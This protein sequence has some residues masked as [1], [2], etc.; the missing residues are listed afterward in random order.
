MAVSCDVCVCSLVLFTFHLFSNHFH[1][2]NV[3]CQV[4]HNKKVPPYNTINHPIV[5]SCTGLGL[6]LSKMN[7]NQSLY[8]LVEDQLK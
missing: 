2:N 1:F 3:V 4:M 7:A 8:I 6:R 5:A